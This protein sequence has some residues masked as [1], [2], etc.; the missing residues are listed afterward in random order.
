ML[1]DGFGRS[2]KYAIRATDFFHSE[3]FILTNAGPKRL[4]IP[5]KA[6]MV[7]MIDGRVI[8]QSQ[9]AWTPVGATKPYKAGSLLLGR[10]GRAAGRSGARPPTLIYSPTAKEA[11]RARRRPRTC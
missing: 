8:I 2:L 4:V 5:E 3:T 10:S 9:E 11:L 7:D 6:N 1:R